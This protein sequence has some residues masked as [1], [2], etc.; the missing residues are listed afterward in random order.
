MINIFEDNLEFDDIDFDI[1]YDE[2]GEA[3]WIH[4]MGETKLKNIISTLERQIKLL[5]EHYNVEIWQE[6][7][8]ICKEALK[9]YIS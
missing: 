1:Y 2:N 6:Y 4:E 3:E 5:P 7:H 9:K 8:G